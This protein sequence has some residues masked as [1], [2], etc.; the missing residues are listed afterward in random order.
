MREKQV[1]HVTELQGSTANL[2]SFLLVDAQALHDA[3]D[4]F[5]VLADLGLVP[6]RG[7]RGTRLA[8]SSVHQHPLVLFDSGYGVA[9]GW[10][11]HQHASY[12]TLAF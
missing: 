11:Q 3:K 8:T 10:L 7:G 6:D 1:N 9:A 4:L 5:I 2:H 12:Q